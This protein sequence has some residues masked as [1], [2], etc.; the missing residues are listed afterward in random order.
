MTFSINSMTKSFILCVREWHG[1][2]NFKQ[3]NIAFIHVV[4]SRRGSNY[5]KINHALIVTWAL[6]LLFLL[7]TE[8]MVTLELLRRFISFRKKTSLNF[9][10]TI[11]KRG[12]RWRNAS[13]TQETD[14]K[15]E[16][17]KIW[18]TKNVNIQKLKRNEIKMSFFVNE[19]ASCSIIANRLK[20]LWFGFHW[21]IIPFDGIYP[22]VELYA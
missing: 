16:E 12:G 4:W 14:E 21:S 7:R 2:A 9:S 20:M 5:S 1:M 6:P 15:D 22:I 10:F 17:E 11:Q 8:R 18:I 13:K 19:T 3:Q